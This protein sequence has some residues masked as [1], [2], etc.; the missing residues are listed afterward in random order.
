MKDISVIIIIIFIQIDII[1]KYK[2]HMQLQ[3]NL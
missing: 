3:T 1:C 2:L